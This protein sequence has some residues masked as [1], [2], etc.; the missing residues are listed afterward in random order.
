MAEE[1]FG[2]RLVKPQNYKPSLAHNSHASSIVVLPLLDTG[3]L[4]IN[5]QTVTT[6]EGALSA[7]PECYSREGTDMG[8]AGQWVHPVYRVTSDQSKIKVSVKSHTLGGCTSVESCSSEGQRGGELAGNITQLKD[9]AGS[10][11]L[12][13]RRDSAQN[14]S[15]YSTSCTPEV[16]FHD[17][18]YEQ[19]MQSLGAVPVAAQVFEQ[20]RS[21]CIFD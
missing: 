12:P 1:E 3:E 8:V 13:F 21:V 4:P 17:V 5:N 15:P 18:E 11:T 10:K 7:S 20:V 2:Q 19:W 16:G 6:P 14:D 9:G